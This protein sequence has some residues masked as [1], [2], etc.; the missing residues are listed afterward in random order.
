MPDPVKNKPRTLSFLPER[1]DRSKLR[2]DHVIREDLRQ[3]L[4]EM[5]QRYLEKWVWP[6]R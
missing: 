6:C 5:H 4:A 1:L 2:E 3:Q